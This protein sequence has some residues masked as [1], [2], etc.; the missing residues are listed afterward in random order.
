MTTSSAI[1]KLKLSGS[2]DGKPI[3]VAATAS[4]GTTIHTTAALAATVGFDEIWLWAWSTEAS[5]ARVLHLEWGQTGVA[6]QEI[7]VSIPASSGLVLVSPGLIL[8]N[9]LVIKAWASVAS[10]V[11]IVG[12]A[13]TMTIAG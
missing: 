2:T 6:A 8:T 3:A 11:N 1:T 9:S 12:F 13:N 7:I 10:V 5:T 4:A